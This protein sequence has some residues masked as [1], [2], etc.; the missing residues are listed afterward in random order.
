LAILEILI[1]NQRPL[2]LTEIQS[3]TQID[4]AELEKQLS[5]LQEQNALKKEFSGA[6]QAFL[7]LPLGVKLVRYFNSRLY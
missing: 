3:A 6:T 5:F 4:T 1:I 7:L 2:K